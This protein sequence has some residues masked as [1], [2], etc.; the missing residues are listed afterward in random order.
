MGRS[1][2]MIDSEQSAPS[3]SCHDIVAQIALPQLRQQYDS[4]L[5]A[6]SIQERLTHLEH[7]IRPDDLGLPRIE[8]HDARSF[9]RL[10]DVQTESHSVGIPLPLV[11]HEGTQLL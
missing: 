4:A 9:P 8:V 11:F 10:G 5:A 1:R 3:Q 2:P 7:G 6:F